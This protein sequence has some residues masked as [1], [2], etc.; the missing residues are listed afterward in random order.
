MDN[1]D[2][3]KNYISGL[4]SKHVNIDDF[5]YGDFDQLVHYSNENPS[6]T[7]LFMEWPE[8]IPRDSDGSYTAAYEMGVYVLRYIDPQDWDA[9]NSAM[10]NLG[11]IITDHLLP[12]IK[13]ELFEQNEHFT[14]SDQRD[15]E[16]VTFMTV[17]G[18]LGYRMTMRVITHKA[19][20]IDNESAW[21]DRP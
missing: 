15:I 11:V 7:V 12:R 19:L 5:V 13:R 1:L 6:C 8:I 17:A 2:E 14:I 10:S 20:N 4:A 9:R 16:P 18:L 3:L 21:N